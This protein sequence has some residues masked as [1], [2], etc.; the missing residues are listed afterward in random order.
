MM[1][2]VRETLD[3]VRQFRGRIIVVKISKYVLA[4][5]ERLDNVVSDIVSLK[6]AGI[7]VI[8]TYSDATFKSDSWSSLE[9]AVFLNIDNIS[10]IMGQLAMGITPIVFFGETPSLSSEKAIASL[11]IKFGAIKIVYVTNYD[12]IFKAGK[13]LIHE[14]DLEQA[15]E[16]LA[17]PRA[18][19]RE[20]RA[21]LEVA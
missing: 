20:T 9:P 12:G 3:Y 15:R 13:S 1:K 17:S 6:H 4:N 21:Q 5:K 11:A 2:T 8:V 10:A 18:V 14:M 16:M 19:T 7:D